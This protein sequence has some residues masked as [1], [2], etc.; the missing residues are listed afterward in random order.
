MPLTPYQATFP[1][2]VLAITTATPIIRSGQALQRKAELGPCV[3]TLADFGIHQSCGESPN[4]FGA[5]DL[6]DDEYEHLSGAFAGLESAMLESGLIETSPP[7]TYG[8]GG[9]RN[10]DWERWIKVLLPI[11]LSLLA[12][13][14]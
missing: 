14:A 3:L 8:A 13:Q 6:S 5:A 12:K 4:V 2:L 11:L 1:D 10:I 7:A 9:I